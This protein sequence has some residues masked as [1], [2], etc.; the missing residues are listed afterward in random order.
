MKAVRIHEHG[1]PDVLQ[2][3]DVP[4][5][6]CPAH[7]VLVQIKATSI[8]HLDIW[9]R[10][11]VPGVPLPIILGSDGT[12]VIAEI[13]HEI[14]DWHVGEEVMIQPGTYCGH[15]RFCREG[16][17]NYCTQFGIV[18][19]TENGTHCELIAL[20]PKYLE[21]KPASVSFQEAAAFTLVFLTAFTML[22]R[23][24]RIEKGETI[25]VMGAGSGVGSA[26]IQIAKLQGCQVIAT[27]GDEGKL[28]LARELG[29][30][31]FINHYKEKIHERVRDITDGGADIVFEHVGK[32]TW[33]SS[34]RSLAVGG[35][36]VTCGATT[37]PQV[38][39]D[40]RHLYR[41]HHTI[42]GST[43]GDVAGFKQVVQW[44][45]EGK[46]RPVVDRVFSMSSVAE[47]HQYIE[48]GKQ[49]GKV[50]MT[51]DS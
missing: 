8:N 43:M 15:C 13:G 17:E 11:G 34:L 41:K 20:E 39:I 30:D 7:K 2:W 46:V 14:D 25:L 21:R 12:G 22:M 9:V 44:L 29:A 45:G 28:V 35:R 31:H 23:R 42:M 18:G 3:E 48:E 5:P 24:A 50:V 51:P 27:G 6:D 32:A 47:A 16:K 37:G 19:E 4:E 40:L 38:D 33:S 10:K 1:G 36:I 26:A 49:L